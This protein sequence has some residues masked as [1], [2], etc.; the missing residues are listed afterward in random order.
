[1]NFGEIMDMK[2]T[3]EIV[4]SLANKFALEKKGSLFII[5]DKDMSKQ[6]DLL[7]PDL[8]S[9][10][11]INIKNNAV[12][13]VIEKLA[14]LDGAFIIDTKGKI[15]AYGAKI[16]KTK[17]FL[18]HGT[19][20][21]AA[22]GVSKIDNVMA[23]LSS[24]EDGMVR[25]FKKGLLNAE[26]NPFTGKNKKF[27]EKLADLFTK[28]EI[29]VATSGGVA[30]LLIGINP[31]LAGAIFTG[32]WIVTKYGM[33]SVKDFIN[34]GRIVVKENIANIKTNKK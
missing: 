32:S 14:D 31:L 12:R 3:I 24:E 28:P 1:M 20:H 5:T 27:Y 29:Q 11:D 15:I 19:R 23:I 10:R 18:G 6:Y 7:Y 26:I 22:L 17:V 30:S 2:E 34:T 9:N 21:S 13:I 33:A 8:F 4:L 25:I 16:K